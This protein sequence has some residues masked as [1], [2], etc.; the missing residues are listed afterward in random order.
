[1]VE[2]LEWYAANEIVLFPLIFSTVILAGYLGLAYVNEDRV[3]RTVI[4]VPAIAVFLVAYTNS[5]LFAREWFLNLGVELLTALLAVII[6]G[7]AAMFRD[8]LFAVVMVFG[9]VLFLVIFID[10]LQAESNFLLTFS[11]SL[12]GALL[13]AYLLREEWN[14]SV[15]K[16]GYRLRRAMRETLK[17]AQR[18][19]DEGGDFYILLVGM[20]D[21]EIGEK[22]DFLKGAQL[23]LLRQDESERDE[24]TGMVFKLVTARIHQAAQDLDTILLAGDE[25]RVRIVAYRDSAKRIYA[26][27]GEVLEC[28]R[29]R[30]LDSPGELVHFEFKA[31]TPPRLFSDVLE[32]QIFALAREWRHGEDELLAPATDAL[33]AWGEKNGFIKPND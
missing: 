28:E 7:I 30:R 16:R 11:T 4:I 8:W 3:F 14:Y 29:P 19:I 25:A 12:V 17:T 27:M 13:T 24:K 20:D 22:L 2:I 21:G 23:D 32:E 6:V 33:I 15:E 31:K 18:D 26:Q 1:M 10:P 9:V 5:D